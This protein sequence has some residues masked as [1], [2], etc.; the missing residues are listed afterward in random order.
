MNVT[1]LLITA[2]DQY[3]AYFQRLLPELLLYVDRGNFL[4]ILVATNHHVEIITGKNYSITPIKVEAEVWPYSTTKRYEYFAN[5]WYLVEGTNIIWIDADMKIVSELS[6]SDI[7]SNK[8]LILSLHPGFPIIKSC[9]SKPQRSF[10]RLFI[11]YIYSKLALYFGQGGWE[12]QKK[13]TAFVP[14]LKR[15]NYF[16]GGFWIGSKDEAYDLITY[17]ASRATEDLEKNGKYALHNDESYLNK[18]A[19]LREKYLE[20]LPYGFVTAEGY[21]W[22]PV[23]QRKIICLEKKKLG[24]LNLS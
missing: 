21:Y 6:T 16:Q 3:Y 12:C 11:K 8:K 18:Y 20:K 10:S 4:Q 9:I 15:R 2:T 7:L 22:N 1:S 17:I 23:S 14:L 19:V 13:S 24:V 5:H